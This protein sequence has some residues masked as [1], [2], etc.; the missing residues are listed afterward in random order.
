[1]QLSKLG[2]FKN[3]IYS[4]IDQ[5]FGVIAALLFSIVVVKYYGVSNYGLYNIAINIIGITS[6]IT[7]FGIA[8]HLNRKIAGSASAIGLYLSQGLLLRLF[9]SLPLTIFI[10]VLIA[11]LVNKNDLILYSG[12][13]A[14]NNT[15]LTSVGLI[16]GALISI[17]KTDASTKINITN[18]I[19]LLL[20]CILSGWFFEDF[21]YAQVG[22]IFSSI[23]SLIYAYWVAREIGFKFVGKIKFRFINLLIIKSRHLIVASSSEYLNLK[24][25][26]LI[27]GYYLSNKQIGSYSIAYNLYMG[28]TL[29]PLAITRNMFVELVS[30]KNNKRNFLLKIKKYSKFMC[31]YSFL[32]ILVTYIFGEYF[33]ST[34][35]GND[36]D[37][38]LIL[39]KLIF[40]LPVIIINRLLN[41]S[42]IAAGLV[43][44]YRD[45]TLWSTVLMVTLSLFLIP[46]Y[47][48]SG[49]IFVNFI[50]ETIVLTL[51]IAKIIRWGKV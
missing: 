29:L 36:Q 11:Y 27:L 16:T 47:G 17:K 6:T 44:G 42:L 46:K 31:L 2:F 5:A 4:I 12:L 10:G 8:A 41:Y 7:S 49:A 24:L 30:D 21:I 22:F 37:A 9:Y 14:I 23:I 33:V 15:L 25:S 20:F 3:A 35:Y 45:I 38:F 32:C 1:M 48:V 39:Y 28:A 40:I 34:L 19:V 18:K 43:K 51:G 50:I 26:M 13:A